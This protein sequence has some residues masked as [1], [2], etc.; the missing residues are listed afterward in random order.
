[1]SLLLLLIFPL[2][3]PFISKMIWSRD[4][5][6]GEIAGQVVIV[7][8]L[9]G[10]TYHLGKVGKTDDTEIYNG[11][12]TAKHRQNGEYTE[13]YSCHCH[14]VCEPEDDDGKEEESCHDECETCY[15]EHYT[16]QWWL[17]STIGV[18]DV[19]SADWLSPSV[20]ALP[21]PP[22]YQNAAPGQ[23]CSK[24]QSYTNYVKAVPNS[25]FGAMSALT[26]QQ[27]VHQIPAY[28]EVYNLYHI[29]RIINVGSHVDAAILTKF[30]DQLNDA[31]KTLGPKKQA[32]I[33]VI[34]TSI[35]DDMYRYAVENAW[36]G[37]KKND[38]VVFIGSKDGHK[39]DW[40]DVMTWAMNKGNGLFHATLQ[41]DINHVGVIDPDQLVPVI[42][43][44]V[45]KYYT[46]PHMKDFKYLER[47]I[48]PP[49]WVLIFALILGIVGS[50]GCTYFFENIARQN[51]GYY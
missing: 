1:M 33:I 28:P 4:I 26:Q 51:R 32:N 3:W 15:R 37:G 48:Q 44:D 17:E 27:Y 34:V 21:D 8:L 7:C 38:I 39:I 30:N 47:E 5:T 50:I 13:S 40:V 6:W 31:N 23:A 9:V 46:R 18:Y 22:L 29:D 42:A 45:D 43:G 36:L 10:L 11:Q 14:E 12:I 24:E 49:T 16:V 25:L 20:Y 19:D 41:D 35:T 2:I